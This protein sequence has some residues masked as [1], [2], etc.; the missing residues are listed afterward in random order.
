MNLLS[1][2]AKV[3]ECHDRALEATAQAEG[4]VLE[5]VREKHEISAARWRALA[6]LYGGGGHD[7]FAAAAHEDD[8]LLS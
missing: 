7:P 6:V 5:G 8:V 1:R 3:A 4:A 2:E